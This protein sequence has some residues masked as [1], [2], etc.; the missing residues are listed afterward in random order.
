ME[1][2][3][4][5]KNL[6]DLGSEVPPVDLVCFCGK[7]EHIPVPVGR[8]KDEEIKEPMARDTEDAGEP[9][10]KQLEPAYIEKTEEIDTMDRTGKDRFN[11]PRLVTVI[12]AV[13]IV[14]F[15][16]WW[17][18]VN[19][20]IREK[21][22]T[23]KM[24]ELVQKQRDAREAAEKKTPG[25]VVVDTVVGEEF[26]GEEVSERALEEEEEVPEPEPVQE[27]RP[28][29]GVRYTIHVAS[30]KDIVRAGQETEYLERIGFDVKVTEYE[31]KGEVWFRVYVGEFDTREEATQVKRELLEINRIGYARVVELE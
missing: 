20:S 12:I 25:P 2:G 24:T 21:E 30:F 17:I 7:K 14:A 1:E 13:L 8:E 22:S 4:L 16:I 26:V 3:Q 27:K 19:R 29:V 18:V 28:Q 5:Q 11:L 10:E 23:Q 9:E 15:L 31:V 6:D